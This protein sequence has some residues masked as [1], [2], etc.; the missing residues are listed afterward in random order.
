MVDE[1]ILLRETFLSG[2]ITVSGKYSFRY[3]LSFRSCL[4]VQLNR[5]EIRI[6][7]FG[8]P[9]FKSKLSEV[10]IVYIKINRFLVP[11]VNILLN[12]DRGFIFVSRHAANWAD[13]LRELRLPLECDDAEIQKSSRLL[14]HPISNIIAILLILL[15]LFSVYILFVSSFGK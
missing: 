7:V 8:L 13:K 6:S 11:T 12:D 1:N 9:V 15:V 10:K 2:H 3:P 14:K 4:T 5:D